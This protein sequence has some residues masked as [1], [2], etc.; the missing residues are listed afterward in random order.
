MIP[1]KK[2]IINI[3]YFK[4]IELRKSHNKLNIFDYLV[5]SSLN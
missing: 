3:G 5:E 2:S 1:M 4:D